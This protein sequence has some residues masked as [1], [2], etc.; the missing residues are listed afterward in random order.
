LALANA[1]QRRRLI[2]FCHCRWPVWPD[3]TRYTVKDA[4]CH[5]VKVASLL[6]SA[7]RRRGIAVEIVEWPR[8]SVRSEQLK[9]S[10]EEFRRTRNAATIRLG[11][12]LPSSRLLGLPWDR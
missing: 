7:A 12:S 2:F 8:G 10:P 6:R 3:V 5:R 1:R 11:T 9:L 4:T